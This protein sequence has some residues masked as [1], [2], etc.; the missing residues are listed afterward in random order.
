VHY[1]RQLRR[2]KTDEITKKYKLLHAT[3][4]LDIVFSVTCYLELRNVVYVSCISHIL[5][6]NVRLVIQTS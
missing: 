1:N 4:T 2:A 3:T 5:P 6:T